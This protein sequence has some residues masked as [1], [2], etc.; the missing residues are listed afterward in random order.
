MRKLLFFLFSYL[1]ILSAMADEDSYIWITEIDSCHTYDKDSVSGKFLLRR[2]DPDKLQDEEGFSNENLSIPFYL[3]IGS[4]PTTLAKT[5]KCRN[6]KDFKKL[7]KKPYAYDRIW[8]ECDVNEDGLTDYI[9][10]FKDTQAGN[11]VPS[12]WKEDSLVDQNPRGIMLVINRG[13]Y[14]ETDVR[15]NSCFTSDSEYGGVY[16]APELEFSSKGKQIS[17]FYGHGRYGNWSYEFEYEDGDFVMTRFNIYEAYGPIMVKDTRVDFKKGAMKI[18]NLKGGEFDYDEEP[19]DDGYITFYCK[20]GVK[21][22][23]R[24]TDINDKF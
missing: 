4:S 2:I 10:G 8:G 12:Q 19:D 18:T 17:I 5:L 24:L 6:V 1:P 20:F 13:K 21:K 3:K 7:V 15:N 14:F 22:A 23:I 16:F 11:W 9:I